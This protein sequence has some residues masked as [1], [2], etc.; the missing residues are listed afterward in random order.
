MFD[1]LNDI[2]LDQI[3]GGS[4]PAGFVLLAEVCRGGFLVR[5]YYNPETGARFA[6]T[7]GRC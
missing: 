2:E 1:A 3:T 5:Y 7:A 4:A 6:E